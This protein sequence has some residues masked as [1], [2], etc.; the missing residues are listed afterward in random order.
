VLDR[1]SQMMVLATVVAVILAVAAGCGDDDDET[2]AETT[3]TEAVTTGP[4]EDSVQQAVD[5]AVSTC[6]QIAT[7][8]IKNEATRNTAVSACEGVGRSLEQEVA[9]L[10]ASAREDVDAALKELSANCRNLV[11]DFP[12][13]AK[14]TLLAACDQLAAGG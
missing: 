12:E 11:A 13:P 10:S 4:V 1:A 3:T 5:D 14:P 2:A 7:A 6:T 8:N 9:G